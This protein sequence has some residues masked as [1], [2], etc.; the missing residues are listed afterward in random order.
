MWDGITYP[1]PHF[2]GCT[3][4]F[5]EWINNFT[6][7]FVMDV[8]TFPFGINV[9]P[10]WWK[11]SQIDVIRMVNSSFHRELYSL[12]NVL[13]GLKLCKAINCRTFIMLRVCPI[14][15]IMNTQ[16]VKCITMF[17]KV[18]R[19]ISFC[20][21]WLLNGRCW[22]KK[23]CIKMHLTTARMLLLADVDIVRVRVRKLYFKSIQ[24]K[25][26]DEYSFANAALHDLNNVQAMLCY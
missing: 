23:N 14:K 18:H 22:G 11:E 26:N 2:S 21:C 1:I 3:I 15:K 24:N 6:L 10:C 13:F 16:G 4:E 20:R 9:N 19:H 7:H 5:G 12:W 25:I 17:A 8:I